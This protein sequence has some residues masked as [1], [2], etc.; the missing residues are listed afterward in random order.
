MK[1]AARIIIAAGAPLA[2][3]AF[4]AWDINPGNWDWIT[5]GYAALCSVALATATAFQKARG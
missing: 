4:V 2:V 5:R 3:F 1:C